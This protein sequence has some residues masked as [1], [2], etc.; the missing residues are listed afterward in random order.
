VNRSTPPLASLILLAALAQGL[1]AGSASAE[2]ADP[3]TAKATPL[4]NEAVALM[5]RRKY[6]EACPKLEEVVRL[7]PEGIGAKFTLAECYEESGRLATAWEAF[8]VVEEMAAKAGQEERQKKA[9]ARR[10]ALEPRLARLTIEVPPR[11]RALPDLVILRDGV[12]VDQA[13]WGTP[14]PVDKGPRTVVATA[15]QGR[16]EK[17]INITQNGLAFI[18]VI[19]GLGGGEPQAAGPPK[20]QPPNADAAEPKPGGGLG[21]PRIAGI[22]A[23][24]VGAA[25]A[26]V[27]A[28]F[29][30]RAVQKKDESNDGY[31][32]ADNRCNKA[33][34][35]LRQEGLAAATASTVLF[36][37]GGAALAGGAV[38][39]LTAPKS[40]PKSA[41]VAIGPGTLAI[42]G[43]W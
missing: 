43:S 6:S 7:I 34:L 33:G 10:D 4:Y 16:F 24:G 2:P 40:A 26:G 31:C 13:Q 11:A 5:D 41:Q 12:K 29:G 32:S 1:A 15:G 27:G 20:A 3:R 30:V 21:A 18:V 14:V 25:S 36:A 42:R 19:E 22:I 35:E 8:G 9:R 17:T 28:Y 23:L 39:I 38:L 37:V